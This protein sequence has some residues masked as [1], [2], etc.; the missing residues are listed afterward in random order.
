MNRSLNITFRK[1]IIVVFLLLFSLNLFAGGG[2]PKKKGEGYFKFGQGMIRSNRYYTPDGTFAKITTTSYYISSLYGEYGLTNR[3]TAVGYF[4]FLARVTQ[5]QVVDAKTKNEI[6]PG[7]ELTS[8]GDATVGLKYGIVPKG[9]VV[10]SVQLDLKMPLGKSAGGKSKI[11]QTGDGAFSQLVKT[12][13]STSKG[14]FYFTG[15]L[16]LR[17]RGNQYSDD[18]HS[19]IEIGWNKNKRFYAIAKL[20]AV[21]SFFNHNEKIGASNSLFGNNTEYIGFGP[22]FHYFFKN[23]WGINA[24]VVGA[25]QG[26]NVLANPF[27]GVG[28]SYDLKKK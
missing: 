3:F 25:L 27:W 28:I 8:L 16:G 2:W 1:N 9:K 14:A 24:T 13:V 11:L 20:N 15:M 22:E 5:N 26:R 7:D 4:P 6:I 12:E 18:W 17:H 21:Q 19:G 10:W 23:N